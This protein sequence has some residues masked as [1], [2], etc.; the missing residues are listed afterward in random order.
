MLRA[1]SGNA[2]NG[3]SGP[4]WTKDEIARLVELVKTFG[5][6]NRKNSW[7]AWSKNEFDGRTSKSLKMFYQ[8]HRGTFS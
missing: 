6:H 3:T 8:T 1:G 4:T 5:T 2:K 7:S